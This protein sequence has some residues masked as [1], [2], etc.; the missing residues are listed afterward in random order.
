MKDLIDENRTR[1]QVIVEL[2]HLGCIQSAKD[3]KRK[4]QNRARI[5]REEDEAQLM[6]L[7]H[8]HKHSDDVVG[9]ILPLLTVKRSKAKVVEKLLGLELV[10]DRKALYKRRQRK[11][12]GRESDSDAERPPTS[13]EFVSSDSD[14]ESD[15]PE[16]A[17]SERDGSGGRGR[18]GARGGGRSSE[19][20]D[21]EAFMKF[22]KTTKGKQNSTANSSTTTA[23]MNANVRKVKESGFADQLLWIL[24]SFTDEAAD[25]DE[26][27]AEDATPVVPLTE[28]QG[29]ALENAAFSA[30]VQWMGARPPADGQERYWR[31]P[32]YLS[33]TMLRDRVQS[34]TE[35]LAQSTG[36]GNRAA[37]DGAAPGQKAQ[38]PNLSDD[39]DAEQTADGEQAGESRQKARPTARLKKRVMSESSED[40][41][42][43]ALQL[44]LDATSPPPKRARLDVEESDDEP[45]S[46]GQRP[47]PDE[48]VSQRMGDAADD[49]SDSDLEEKMPLKR[50]IRRQCID[51]E[52]DDD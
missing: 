9:A 4:K 37:S 6:A 40:D 39:S 23:S 29:D 49:D 30:V 44:V 36:D 48:N 14:S 1:R 28:A 35:A 20:E 46:V 2:A 13:K 5:W 34:V 21:D 32:E 3:L 31:I 45:L 25:R 43:N 50:V 22:I 26:E 52:S 38:P 7:F 27:K 16:G 12:A 18:G 17:A 41:D 47:T 10:S 51:S 24:T 11:K 8:E 19:S 33:A 15:A 42:D